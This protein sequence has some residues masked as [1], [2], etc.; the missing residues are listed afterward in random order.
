MSAL[1]GVEIVSAREKLTLSFAT[2]NI[3]KGYID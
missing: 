3:G 1:I 2:G